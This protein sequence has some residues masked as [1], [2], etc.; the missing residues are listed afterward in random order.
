MIYELT[1]RYDSRLSFYGKAI[2]EDTHDYIR[3]Y[4]YGTLVCEILNN[5]VI[6]Y[7]TYSQT[8]LRH[9]K[10]FLKQFEYK[11]ETKKQ[12]INDYMEV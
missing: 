6:V 3:L 11:A 2:I 1:P 10:E 8:T 5:K 4:S 7:G 12:I 9:I